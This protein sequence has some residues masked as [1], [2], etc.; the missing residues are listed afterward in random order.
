MKKKYS[1]FV[2][3]VRAYYKQHGRDLP[4][5][6]TTDPYH[7]LV[8]EIM[9]QQTQVDRVIPKY[10]TFIKQFPTL[11]SLAKAKP[12]KVLSLWQG[13]GYNSR[14]LRLQQ[15]ARVIL[16]K[17]ASVFPDRYDDIMALPGVGPATAGDICAF[18]WNIPHPVIETNIR[19]VYIH[20]FF[21]NAEKVSDAELLPIITQ[22]LD[23]KNPREWYWA[24]FDYGA[25]LKKQVKNNT[26]SK[27]YS[28][29]SR[30]AGSVRQ[31]RGAIVRALL[32]KQQSIEILATQLECDVPTLIPIITK[33][34]Q[35]G[36]VKEK[37]NRWYI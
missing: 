33:M 26:Q 30:F 11:G 5:R 4:W 21:K 3:T 19:S 22:T 9:L 1:R 20:H 2:E 24:L 8:S 31:K 18:A 14:A 13:L 10:T 17:H 35:E 12:K 32:V 7:I 28:K 25:H 16:Q 15:A 6:K 36:V 37:N 27:H 34:K 23:Q 29:Q